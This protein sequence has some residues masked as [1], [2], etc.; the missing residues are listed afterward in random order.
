ILS[1][2]IEETEK[3]EQAPLRDEK[4]K[5]TKTEAKTED[6]KPET[7]TSEEK[8]EEAK[9]EE[10]QPEIQPEPR[11]FKLKYKGEEM[12]KDEPE[13]I[14]LAQKGYD[15][16]QKSQALAKEREELGL[17]VKAD[18][19]AARR[20]LEQQLE[21]HRQAVVKLSGVKTMAEIEQLSKN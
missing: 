2:I 13:V 10:E 8:A 16:T 14:E 5:F 6:A 19:E 7:E 9:P 21:V 11:R 3:A 4:G 18:Q 1:Q 15:Y 12:E 17:K 20:T